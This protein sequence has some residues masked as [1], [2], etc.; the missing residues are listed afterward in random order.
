VGRPLK[1]LAVVPNDPLAAYLAG[2]YEASWLRAYYNPGR[3]FDEVYALSPMEDGERHECGMHVIPTAQN[4]FKH[5]IKELGIDVVRVY[6]GT[7]AC[8][9]ACLNKVSGVPVVVSLHDTRPEWVHASIGRADVVLCVSEAVKRTALGKFRRTDRLWMRPNG[10]DFNVMR[11][12]A[13]EELADL[14]DGC[15]FRYKIVHVGR[16]VK[17]KNLETLIKSLKILG[18]DYGLWAFGRGDEKQYV[19]L[20]RD[21]GVL[22]RCR[23]VDSVANRDLARYCSWADCFCNPSRWEGMSFALIE[24]LACNAVVVV[25]DI[26]EMSQYVTHGQNGLLVKDYEDAAVLAETIQLACTDESARQV[27]KQNARQS[28]E[29]FEKSRIESLEAGYYQRVLEMK[30]EGCFHIPAWMQALDAAQTNVKRLMPI[31][32][33]RMVRRARTGSRQGQG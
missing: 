13:P 19:T 7:R 14:D 28:V 16:K 5:R 21:Q 15:P 23:F 20:A 29:Q 6:G 17:Q 33:K 32:V 25:S 2:G 3:F 30:A 26:S 4:E 10:V 1:R 31:R 18:D 22:G 27:F 9:F 24:A 8:D 11:P 12:Y